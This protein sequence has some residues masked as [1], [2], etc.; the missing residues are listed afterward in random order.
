MKKICAACGGNGYFLPPADAKPGLTH[1]TCQT[2]KG[3]GE[4]VPERPDWLEIGHAHKRHREDQ[5]EGL[6]AC[7]ERL[8][9]NVRQLDEMERGQRHPGPIWDDIPET[10]RPMKA[11]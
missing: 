6:A 2:C 11:A 10:L 4:I 9:I 1:I 8:E 7:A 5:K 3:A